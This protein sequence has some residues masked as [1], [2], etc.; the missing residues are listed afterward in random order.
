MRRRNRVLF[1]GF[2]FIAIIV[3]AYFLFKER[4]ERYISRA[5]VRIARNY[6][7]NVDFTDVKLR[8]IDQSITLKGV[9]ISWT[10]GGVEFYG[11]I[12]DLT[13]KFRR[14]ISNFKN[15]LRAV[16]IRNAWIKLK[17]KGEE[18]RGKSDL[19]FLYN[20]PIN[21]E[22]V[23][24]ELFTEEGSF[25]FIFK[26]WKHL[27]KSGRWHEIIDVNVAKAIYRNR[28][29]GSADLTLSVSLS[30]WSSATGN[31]RGSTDYGEVRKLNFEWL[32][33][34]VIT[35]D[36]EFK[37]V[38]CPPLFSFCEGPLSFKSITLKGVWKYK[39]NIFEGGFRFDGLKRGRFFVTEGG[40]MFRM[41][42]SEKSAF[43]E[44][45]KLVYE[46]SDL[47]L[48]GSIGKNNLNISVGISKLQ[49]EK[50]LYALGVDTRV[51]SLYSG[52]IGLQGS[53]KP[54]LIKGTGKLEAEGFKVCEN[55]YPSRCGNVIIHNRRADVDLDFEID[56]EKVLL[57]RARV[58]LPRGIL[59]A[60]GEIN[61]NEYLD[62]TVSVDGFDVS[63]VS[64]IGG[65]PMKGYLKGD[66]YIRGPFEDIV[67][68]YSG[69]VESYGI[70]TASLGD[71]RTTVY[72]RDK[73]MFY[74]FSNPTLEGMGLI[75]FNEK[76]RVSH[77]SSFRDITPAELGNIVNLQESVESEVSEIGGKV[78]GS[79][80]IVSDE[81]GEFI[82]S[83]VLNSEGRLYYLNEPVDALHAEGYYHK[84][85]MVYGISGMKGGKWWGYGE[86][87]NGKVFQFG[88]GDD[89][90]TERFSSLA[91][92]I[93][94]DVAWLGELNDS[95]LIYS[96]KEKGGAKSIFGTLESGYHIIRINPSRGAIFWGRKGK[97]NNVYGCA[98]KLNVQDFYTGLKF[99]SS[100]LNI[101]GYFEVPGNKPPLFSIFPSWFKIK[102]VLLEGG[103]GSDKA[104]FSS[105]DTWVDI[106][107]KGSIFEIE[108][109]VPAEMF[110][111]Y[112]DASFL[113]GRAFGKVDVPLRGDI[114]LNDVKG[115]F[116]LDGVTARLPFIYLEKVSGN[117]T[118]E[119]GIAKVYLE[120]RFPL[121]KLEGVYNFKTGTT[122]G[123]IEAE[124]VETKLRGLKG[125]GSLSARWF[126]TRDRIVINGN[127]KITEGFIPFNLIK[128]NLVSTSF[129]LPLFLENFSVSVEGMKI[130]GGGVDLLLE[131]ILTL[132]GNVPRVDGS[133]EMNL[134]GKL[135]YLGK[136]FEIKDGK[137]IWYGNG[138]VPYIEILASTEAEKKVL[139]I[140][141][142]ASVYTIYLTVKGIPPDLNL[143]LYSSPPLTRENILSVLFTGKTIEDIY[144]TEVKG[145]GASA[146]LSN[147][148]IGMIMGEELRSISR[149]SGLD[150]FS[151]Y[152]RYSEHL[153][154]TTTYLRVGKSIGR[155]LWMEYVRDLNFD[156]QEFLLIW[157]P[158]SRFLVR[159][160]W[161]NTYTRYQLSSQEFGNLSFDL[162]FLNEF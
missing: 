127:A 100:N 72:Y 48:D 142:T 79:F 157:K 141:E 55:L 69:D 67:V 2:I 140:G 27:P 81:D 154:R 83:G 36:G 74:S 131:G 18:G 61:F 70:F 147:V 114:S 136:E 49:F 133:G 30:P 8:Y 121:I 108:F 149:A 14:I 80:F 138:A 124:K 146:Q 151:V 54:L 128:E 40:G 50:L 84:G 139:R 125:S 41:N 3:I 126:G 1:F 46:G 11:I 111:G 35:F 37:E 47:E 4:F 88:V 153:N 99:L 65:V 39:E 87:R 44:G 24:F 135:S 103:N 34:K 13:L 29:I 57:K 109:N 129:S 118:I 156:E 12:G 110:S 25:R 160:G 152:P 59:V 85:L 19:N 102:D 62:L 56:A 132:K 89:I 31:L 32:R 117:I 15:I 159:G 86:Y 53:L 71:G 113:D 38:L 162:L 137:L 22:N 45:I 20:F 91:E 104:L 42:L 122:N 116:K 155:S 145:K 143:D 64:P 77:V 5:V 78:S 94:V 98:E 119:D 112:L 115:K 92:E 51:F 7:V 58:H 82:F 150:L 75:E 101:C 9:E 60:R 96:V 28:E 93:S 66:V 26:N 144:A 105:G 63:E 33:G 148:G 16:E 76:I 123:Y 120:E 134:K 23:R 21:A 52:R 73:Q 68:Y 95:S 43:L 97:L 130:R 107:M 106:R 10:R 90:I 161:D 17:L 158:S 6:G